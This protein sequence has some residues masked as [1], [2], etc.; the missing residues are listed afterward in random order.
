MILR[1]SCCTIL[2]V[3]SQRYSRIFN[4]LVNYST[5]IVDNYTLHKEVFFNLCCLQT[6]VYHTLFV[7]FFFCTP[8]MWHSLTH[9]L[10]RWDL[11]FMYLMMLIR[12]AWLRIRLYSYHE[13]F[14]S[15]SSFSV[16]FQIFTFF[17]FCFLEFSLSVYEKGNFVEVF[18]NLAR[19]ADL[20][21]I[22]LDY[23]N[24]CVK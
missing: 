10:K 7:A 13:A 17:V 19:D 16:F 4:I 9:N 12:I 18:K 8:N 15:T 20:K 6:L 11:W 24:N 23:Q 5:Y 21:I 1:R 3:A 14:S 2:K 22:L